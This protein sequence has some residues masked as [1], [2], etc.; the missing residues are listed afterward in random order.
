MFHLI[1]DDEWNSD[2]LK[3]GLVNGQSQKNLNLEI[4][5][6]EES[7]NK[8]ANIDDSKK[9]DVSKEYISFYKIY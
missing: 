7:D 6:P 4:I 1:D 3:I 9:I 2:N 5:K 8:N